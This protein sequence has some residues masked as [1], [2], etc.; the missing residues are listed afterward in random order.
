MNE[1]TVSEIPICGCTGEQLE[2]MVA[3]CFQTSTAVATSFRCPCGRRYTLNLPS[4]KDDDA[5]ESS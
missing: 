3:R 4:P 5:E 2:A 1:P